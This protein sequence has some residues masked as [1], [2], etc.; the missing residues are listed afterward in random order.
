MGKKMIMSYNAE[1]HDCR[2]SGLSSEWGE[3]IEANSIEEAKT[4]A[5]KL[6]LMKREILGDWFEGLEPGVRGKIYAFISSPDRKLRS[7]G[8]ILFTSTNIEDVQDTTSI[9][10]QHS[11]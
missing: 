1:R 11:L 4:K 10:Q 3:K 2:I 6:F 7:S 9:S 5:K 8:I